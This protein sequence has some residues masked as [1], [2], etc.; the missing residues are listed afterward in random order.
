MID[1]NKRHTLALLII[2]FVFSI[3]YTQDL[4]IDLTLT[5]VGDD[6]FSVCGGERPVVVK[7]TN[8][9]GETLTDGSFTLD[10]S[11]VLGIEY[12]GTVSSIS[13]TAPV[14]NP[15]NSTTTQ[16]SF[17]LPDLTNN[18]VIEFVI[19]LEADC[20]AIA[21]AGSGGTP[22]FDI[23]LTY[24]GGLSTQSANSGN[25]EVVKPALT[26]VDITGN[27]VPPPLVKTGTS[28]SFFDA[29]L[30]QTDILTTR[31]VNGGN[32]SLDEYIYYVIDHPLLNLDKVS[33][34][35]YDLPLIG[36]SNDTTFFAVDAT[37]IALA[38]PDATSPV[39]DNTLFQFNEIM[40]F[41]ETWTVTGCANT[42]PDLERGVAFGCGAAASDL[43]EGDSQTSGLRFGFVRPQLRSSGA[44][45]EITEAERTEALPAC[46]NDEILRQRFW[47][48]NEG[49][50]PA[51]NVK[52]S[53]SVYNPNQNP[54]VLLANNTM[55]SIGKFGTPI[56]L[57][58][59]QTYTAN[60]NYGSCSLSNQLVSADYELGGI[61]LLVPPGYFMDC[62]RIGLYRVWM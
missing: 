48:V 50:A 58:P 31:I 7:L 26:I 3:G 20:G 15:G 11:N 29:N 18:E 54:K 40:T 56:N 37:A 46:Y 5:S 27:P 33:I 44:W 39:D 21:L 62:F 25:F 30:G 45:G 51:K 28:A 59:V 34:G 41:E 19:G 57:T 22:N 13:G 60:Q 36:T 35:T 8:I 43:C 6:R 12:T 24:T 38:V 49:G 52:F 2:L 9:S 32:G 23:N 1:F 17:D 4:Q 10:L 61:D 42:F 47:I 55:V 53:L 14:Y 16:E